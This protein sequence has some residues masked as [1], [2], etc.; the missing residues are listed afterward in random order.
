LFTGAQGSTEADGA[1][2]LSHAAEPQD[3]SV[4]TWAEN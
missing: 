1:P 2:E 4:K 3:G